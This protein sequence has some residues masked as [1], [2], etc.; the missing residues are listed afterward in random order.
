MPLDAHTTDE[1]GR[2]G[3]GLGERRDQVRRA[4]RIGTVI[5]GDGDVAIPRDAA[6]DRRPLAEGNA[7]RNQGSASTL[8][9]SATASG[10]A[11][12]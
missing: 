11:A 10:A 3:P 4:G 5:E 9:V 1:E 7:K 2:A 8:A 12:L 6:D